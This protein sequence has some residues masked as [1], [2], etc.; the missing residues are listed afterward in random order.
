MKYPIGIQNFEQIR[1][2]GY[3]YID[4]TALIYDL[5]ANGKIYF[6]SRPR[7]FGKSLLIST[8]E[9]YF[10]GRKE[11]FRG[12]AIDSLEKEWAEYPVF[13]IDFNGKNFT[14]PLELKKTIETFVAKCEERYGRD[15]LADTFG[16]RLAY[17]FEKAHEKTGRRVVVLID[18]YDKPLLD[19]MSTGIPSPVV[20]GNIKTLE[21]YN[22]EMLKGF[23][24]VFKLT[25]KH[26]QFV[27]LTG[28]TKFSQ[29]SV[30]SGFN[31]PKDISY[32]SRYDALCGITKEELLSVFKEQIRELGESN[33][34]TEEETI[35][36]LKRK[37][38]GYHFTWPSP[39]I[40][41]PFSLLNAFDNEEINDYWFGSGTPTYLIEMM[42]KFHTLPTEIG[43]QDCLASEF[44]APTERMNSIVPL[45]YQSG[46]IT[47]KEGDPLFQTYSLDIPNQEVRIGLMKS[48][49]SNYVMPDSAAPLQLIVRFSRALLQE[50]M[51]D[52]LRLLQTFLSTVPYTDNIKDS[53]GHYQQML[54]VIF[55][56]F[57]MY[58]DV[59]VRTPVG[60]VD[61]VLRTATTLYVVELK[62]NQSAEAAMNQIDLKQ[63]PERFRLSGL[64]IVKV[65]INFD[66]ERH[67]L[68]DWTIEPAITHRI[69]RN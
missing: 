66:S 68:H 20:E 47:I 63:Y 40:Y 18:E 65:G 60:R 7:R 10:L 35:E 14:S 16:D 27:L 33:G 44:D 25:D 41:N 57:G 30:F 49:L 62:L 46:Y 22:R 26:L 28:V 8:L 5:V 6:L 3:V 21:D 53:E 54:Y 69:W 2:D 19:V 39:D 1:E 9:N 61:M 43:R 48:L 58:V 59:E 50:K 38:D 36:K 34:M 52:A 24:S 32:D 56:L 12:L 45:L 17:V 13:H 55:S 23:Y 51:D 31:Q 4:K 64:P 15:E 29:V 37:Y 11:L 67:T 42:R